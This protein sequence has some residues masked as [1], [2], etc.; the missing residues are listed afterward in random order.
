M[1]QREGMIG[2]DDG[3]IELDSVEMAPIED[4]SDS[5]HVSG[6]ANSPLPSWR[7]GNRLSFAVEYRESESHHSKA[8]LFLNQ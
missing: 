2:P 3:I 6:S 8:I 7:N 1:P 4:A 5:A